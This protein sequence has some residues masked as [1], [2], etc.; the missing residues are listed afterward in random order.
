MFENVEGRLISSSLL[1]WDCG[2]LESRYIWGWGLLLYSPQWNIWAIVQAHRALW[3]HENHR[4]FSPVLAIPPKRNPASVLCFPLWVLT[5]IWILGFPWAVLIFASSWW[6]NK[7]LYFLNCFPW[8]LQLRCLIHYAG[9]NKRHFFPM[10]FNFLK[11]Y[12]NK[13]AVKNR[14]KED[15]MFFI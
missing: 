9:R 6:H 15:F 10:E 3:G 12:F 4:P 14:R 8:N 1:H 13:I 5:F 7:L 11:L 2:H